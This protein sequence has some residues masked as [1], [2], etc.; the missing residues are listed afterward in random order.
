MLLLVMVAAFVFHFQGRQT[1]EGQQDDL[2]TA[3]TNLDMTRTQ[4]D[5]AFQS[6][7]ATRLATAQELA[8]AVANSILYEGQLVE[9]QQQVDALTT[10]V[11][12]LTGE[13]AAIGEPPRS[14]P[15]G[16]TPGRNPGLLCS[17]GCARGGN[18]PAGRQRCH[19]SRVGKVAAGLDHLDSIGFERVLLA[20][21][22]R[23]QRPRGDDQ[24]TASIGGQVDAASKPAHPSRASRPAG[25]LVCDR[26]DDRAPVASH[27]DRHGPGVQAVEEHDVGM[28]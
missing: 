9:S 5:I 10:Q 6:V 25:V 18:T 1:L 15:T 19:R 20:E 27:C 17:A 7:E 23:Q 8:T 2:S 4:L 26:N 28:R 22:A 11:D 14:V 16:R 13:L 24:V 21:L 12:D 3:V